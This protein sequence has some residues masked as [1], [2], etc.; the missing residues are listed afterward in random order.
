MTGTIDIGQLPFTYRGRLASG[1][2]VNLWT[3]SDTGAWTF[4]YPIDP[5]DA[6]LANFGITSSAD[7][8]NILDGVTSTAAELNLADNVVASVSW[9]VAAG[10]ANVCHLTGTLKDAAGATIAASRPLFLYI[11]EAATGIGITADTYSTGA[12]ITVG[13]QL[14]ALT[15]NKAW[16]VNAHRRHGAYR[17]HRYGQACRSI[18]R[19]D[20]GAHRRSLNLSGVR[21]IVGCVMA[22]APS[23]TRS[24]TFSRPTGNT[25]QYTA[26]DLVAN[27][28]T[29]GSV[30]MMNWVLPEGGIWLRKIELQK[31]DPDITSAAFRLWL[32][33][34]SA[35][36]FSNGDNGAMQIASTTLAIGSVLAALDVTVDKSLPGAGDTGYATFDAGLHA[37]ANTPTANGVCTIY[38]FLEARGTY[39][40][41]DGESFTVILRGDP[42]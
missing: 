32:H 20:R 4:H 16:L 18:R 13:T 37:L 41:G 9:A 19:R 5:L 27:S 6:S 40:P 38:G 30:V 12:S 29:A 2:L 23:I 42:L 1:E 36:T 11:S 34:D 17:D 10:A 3:I 26:G 33:T 24:A 28:A 8:L 14:V 15:A 25:T 35:V 21:R 22:F 31:S 39:T 7:E